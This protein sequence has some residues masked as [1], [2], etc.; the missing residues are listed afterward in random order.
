LLPVAV[1]LVV[2]Q[3]QNMMDLMVVL[4]V[5]LD[6]A[7]LVE[8]EILHHLLH[9]KEIMVEMLPQ[10]IDPVVEAVVLEASVLITYLQTQV[11]V[12]E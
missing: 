10:P 1:K 9:L 4:V 12:V 3:H 2:V 7:V 11:E 8:T 6:I 5:V